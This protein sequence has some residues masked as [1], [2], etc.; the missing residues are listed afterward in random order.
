MRS[1]TA[2]I[3]KDPDTKLF[4]GYIPGVPGAHSQGSTLD[5]L[6][7]NLEEVLALLTEEGACPIQSDFVGTQHIVMP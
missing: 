3:E 1:Y 4:V 2:V 7:N 6:R 5:E